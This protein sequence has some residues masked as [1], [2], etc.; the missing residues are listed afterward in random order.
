MRK[1]FV[2]TSLISIW[3]MSSISV[4]AE[5]TGENNNFVCI[6]KGIIHFSTRLNT[7]ADRLCN[8]RK[9]NAEEGLSLKADGCA[10]KVN[11]PDY[12]I[13]EQ[14]RYDY[15]DGLAIKELRDCDFSDIAIVVYF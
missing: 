7:Q 2:L 10:M 14:V 13:D 5:S 9:I 4:A 12:V 1:I 15:I 11:N 3:V 8:A 6:P